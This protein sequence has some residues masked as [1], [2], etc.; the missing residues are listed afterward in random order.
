[1][2][3][4]AAALG[5]GVAAAAVAADAGAAVLL[6]KA[7]TLQFIPKMLQNASFRRRLFR[8]R[9]SLKAPHSARL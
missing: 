2:P 4:P 9:R 5:N 6:V 7:A 1:M 3:A 8:P